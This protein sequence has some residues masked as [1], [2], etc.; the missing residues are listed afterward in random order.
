MWPTSDT[1][2]HDASYQQHGPKGIASVP[3]IGSLRS[4]EAW[5]LIVHVG[6]QPSLVLSLSLPF[7]SPAL[8]FR[9]C[10]TSQLYTLAMATSIVCGIVCQQ[11]R[12]VVADNPSDPFQL[13]VI[14]S[15]K[16]SKSSSQLDRL[17]LAADSFCSRRVSASSIGYDNM[18]FAYVIPSAF[19][20]PIAWLRKRTP[21]QR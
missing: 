5:R 21:S 2:R 16:K 4:P 17:C 10:T 19:Y 6:T 12:L 3:S 14:C 9:F 8:S 11:L 1:V 18:T 7:S 15:L 20:P 13:T